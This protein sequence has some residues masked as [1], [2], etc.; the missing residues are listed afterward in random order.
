MLTMASL[1]HVNMKLRVSNYVMYVEYLF[2]I[3]KTMDVFKEM[4][5]AFFPIMTLSLKESF[6]FVKND[7]DDLVKTQTL[8]VNAID[9]ICAKYKK[10]VD[11]NDLEVNSFL[12]DNLKQLLKSHIYALSSEH[13]IKQHMKS[14]D[15]KY[16]SS[17]R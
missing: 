12:A 7:T 2:T 4:F 11:R 13:L 5:S 14:I 8:Y 6:A 1:E 10:P 9:K 16:T 17:M 3:P 15:L